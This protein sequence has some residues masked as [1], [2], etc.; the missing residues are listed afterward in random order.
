MHPLG[1]LGSGATEVRC[2]GERMKA[3]PNCG[4]LLLGHMKNSGQGSHVAEAAKGI[5]TLRLKL[6]ATPI[7]YM[8]HRLKG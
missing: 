7:C 4:S 3:S 5:H 2:L 8:K 6:L 1:C